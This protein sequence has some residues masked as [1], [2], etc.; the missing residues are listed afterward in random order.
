MLDA[1]LVTALMPR[2]AVLVPVVVTRIVMLSGVTPPDAA[3]GMRIFSHRHAKYANGKKPVYLLTAIPIW[4]AKAINCSAPARF[5]TQ[6]LAS[7]TIPV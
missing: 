1:P 7:K 4:A 6:P 5:L 2:M 3:A